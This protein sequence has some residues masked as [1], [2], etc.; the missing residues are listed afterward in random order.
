MEESQEK[1]LY[2]GYI[3]AMGNILWPSFSLTYRTPLTILY[4]AGRLA[5]KL[6]TGITC[7]ILRF[8][9]RTEFHFASFLFLAF[10]FLSF[11]QSLFARKYICDLLRFRK[12]GKNDPDDS[13]LH[14]DRFFLS[15]AEDMLYFLYFL[16]F[17]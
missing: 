10:V 11:T 3:K 5:L 12:W 16:F 13:K 1:W 7:K 17:S 15:D 9:S 2:K 6:K 4:M 8:S 14:P